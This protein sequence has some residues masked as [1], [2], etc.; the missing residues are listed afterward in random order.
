MAELTLTPKVKKVE[1]DGTPVSGTYIKITDSGPGSKAYRVRYKK[2]AA[3]L[4]LKTTELSEQMIPWIVDQAEAAA[5]A[6]LAKQS[7]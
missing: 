6:A 4:G 2:A 5:R 1:E 7:K 3:M